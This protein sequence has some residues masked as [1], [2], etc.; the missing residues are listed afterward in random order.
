MFYVVTKSARV[1]G[2]YVVTGDFFVATELTTTESS[3]AHDRAGRSKAGAHNN[4]APC[5]VATEEAILARQTKPSTH[6]KPWVRTAEAY[7]TE[8]FCHNRLG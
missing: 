6:D 2:I 7:G 3:A 8:E 4:V 5:C 1:G